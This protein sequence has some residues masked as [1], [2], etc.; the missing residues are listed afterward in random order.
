MMVCP[1][2][3]CWPSCTPTSPT[4]QVGLPRG[5]GEGTLLSSPTPRPL[6]SLWAHQR[7][8]WAPALSRGSLGLVLAARP[9]GWYSRPRASSQGHRL[10]PEGAAGM[11]WRHRPRTLPAPPA[12]PQPHHC[13]PGPLFPSQRRG[14]AEAATERQRAAERAPAAGGAGPAPGLGGEGVLGARW[15]AVR[16]P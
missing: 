3:G 11:A 12:H 14:E 13:S 4:R 15:G 1:G 8:F 2:L 9:A 5:V 10:P 16:C 6:D 7:L